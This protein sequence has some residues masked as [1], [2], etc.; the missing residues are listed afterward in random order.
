MK[1]VTL[2]VIAVVHAVYMIPFLDTFT[3]LA[4]HVDTADLVDGTGSFHLRHLVETLSDVSDLTNPLRIPPSVRL[5][6]AV[7]VHFEACLNYFFSAEEIIYC[8]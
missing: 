3:A 1:L 6:S 5:S 8:L 4:S 7:N 2:F